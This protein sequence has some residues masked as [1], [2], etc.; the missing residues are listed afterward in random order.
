MP[1]ALRA[2]LRE[3]EGVVRTSASDSDV[4]RRGKPLLAKLLSSPDAVPPDAFAPRRDRFAMNLIYAPADKAFS[5]NGAVWLPGQTTPIHD[6][7]TW[8]MVGLQ[9]G[10]ERESIFR[11]TDDGSN[12]HMASL[13][14]VSERVNEAGHITTLG[15]T[16]I[17][18]I[19]NVSSLPS[20]SIHIYGVDIGNLER[21]QYDPVTGEVS[22]FVS[23]FCNVLRD[24]DLD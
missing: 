12:P 11:R 13:T 14:K 24:E 9:K 8:A 16:G 7:L 17:H 15:A 4:L 20:R 6:H 23:G 18:R 19:D 21:H 10:E 22:K 2:F 5:V 3:M 1:Y